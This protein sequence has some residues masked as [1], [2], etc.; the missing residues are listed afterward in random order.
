[1]KNRVLQ[2]I[3][4][5]PYLY[6]GSKFKNSANFNTRI[7][8][9]TSIFRIQISDF[10]EPNLYKAPIRKQR[11]LEHTYMTSKE[12]NLYGALANQKQKLVFFRIRIFVR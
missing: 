4:R 11:Y 10:K 6:K 2:R 9:K 8:Q 5:E 12:P 7:N 3:L 1:M